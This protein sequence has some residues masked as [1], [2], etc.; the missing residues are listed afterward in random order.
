MRERYVIINIVKLSQL[1]KLPGYKK[2][3]KSNCSGVPETEDSFAC[4]KEYL[5]DRRRS[6]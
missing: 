1:D 5:T 6:A 2:C 3:A 4:K